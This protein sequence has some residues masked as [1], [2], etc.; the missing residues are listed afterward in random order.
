[1]IAI[2]SP[3]WERVLSSASTPW[4]RLHIAL[5]GAPAYNPR[6]QT[7][8]IISL[9]AKRQLWFNFYSGVCFTLW[10]TR[11]LRPR[12]AARPL[13]AYEIRDPLPFYLKCHL[14][15]CACCLEPGQCPCRS[16]AGQRST[17]L[18]PK[19]AQDF[20]YFNFPSKVFLSREDHVIVPWV[21][22]FSRG[23]S[24][25]LPSACSYLCWCGPDQDLSSTH[26]VQKSVDD[27][28]EFQNC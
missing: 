13:G 19:P 23:T 1:M 12:G 3:N 2:W 7:D 24:G 26:L 25:F 18:F 21:W 16:E 28:R 4:V 15:D 22:H 11:L 20:L 8:I 6:P 9:C 17:L 27:E 14:T 10:V 5:L